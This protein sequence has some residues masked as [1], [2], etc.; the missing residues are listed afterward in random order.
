ME[1]LFV[2]L[3]VNSAQSCKNGP[4]RNEHMVKDVIL[5]SRLYFGIRLVPN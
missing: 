4:P 3:V 5:I 2:M 1:E